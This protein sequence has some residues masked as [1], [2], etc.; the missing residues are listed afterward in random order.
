[1]ALISDV[2]APEVWAR[3][4]IAYLGA[5]LWMAKLVKRDYEKEVK[6]FGDVIHTRKRTA[7]TARS[8]TN[9]CGESA[10]IQEGSITVECLQATDCS[11][12][13]DKFYYTAC[14][15]EDKDKAFSILD[16]RQE[17]V[18][19]GVHPLAV[20]I[21]TSLITEFTTGTDVDGAAVTTGADGTDWGDGAAMDDGDVRWAKYTLDTANCP[22]PGRVFVLHTEH[23]YD[24]L[25]AA[26]FVYADRAGTSYAQQQ[27][28]IPPRFGFEFYMSQNIPTT[29]LSVGAVPQSFAFTKDVMALAMRDLPKPGPGAEGDT[30]AYDGV[31]LRVVIQYEARYKATIVSFDCLYGVRLLENAYGVRVIP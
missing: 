14:M 18:E 30:V 5:T 2:Y 26:L 20:Q 12:T 9:S 19:P 4:S 11:I 25:G 10:M 31:S 29:T 24:L 17:Y 15:I 7:L 28:R 1:M 16:L 22:M 13:L 21:D 23:E 27:G 3:E 8:W 6:Q